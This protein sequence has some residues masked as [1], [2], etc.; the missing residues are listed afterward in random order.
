MGGWD[1]HNVT[2][3]ADL[4]VRLARFGYT[5]ELVNSVT[6]EEANFRIWP[7][8]KQRS[9]WLKGYALTYLVHM[10]RPSNLVGDLGWWGFLGFQV[11]FLGTLSTFFLAPVLW[12]FWP[13]IFGLWH[14]FQDA[15]QSTTATKVA[16]GFF[17][18]EFIAIGVALLAVSA[19]GKRK[20]MWW[21]PTLVAYFPLATLAALK[22][23]AELWDRPFFWDKT[24]K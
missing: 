16:C 20:L 5:T 15:M 8:V 23:L 21:V 14:P 3:D 10:R 11:I 7:W 24:R 13:A 1:A 18:S 6:F 17:A 19:T 22:G 9:R 4:G 2:E 12:T